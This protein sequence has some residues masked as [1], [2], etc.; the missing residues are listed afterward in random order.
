[1]T[2]VEE[3]VAEVVDMAILQQQEMIATTIT[4]HINDRQIIR[5]YGHPD[6]QACRAKL[7]VIDKTIDDL[8]NMFRD[9]NA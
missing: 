1:M 9:G 3:A 5:D 6:C 8:R 7:S 4:H 2:A